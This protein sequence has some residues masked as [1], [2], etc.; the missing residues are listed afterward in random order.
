M[1]KRIAFV[2]L[3]VFLF[4]T[5][6]PNTGD[7]ALVYA[8][9]ATIEDA[10]TAVETAER[11]GAQADIDEA[12]RLI[13]QVPPSDERTELEQRVDVVQQSADV[14]LGEDFSGRAVGDVINVNGGYDVTVQ[15]D[16]ADPANLV[17]AQHYNSTPTGGEAFQH[18]AD[19]PLT[20]RV[21]VEQDVKFAG[22]TSNDRYFSMYYRTAIDNT[23]Y[24][25]FDMYAPEGGYGVRLDYYDA[26]AG[27]DRGWSE[28]PS[29]TSIRY[30]TWY[31]LRFVL[32][33]E[34]NIYEVYMTDLST[35]KEIGSVT[36]RQLWSTAD[37]S[38]GI[39]QFY[40][41]F[42]GSS[43]AQDCYLYFDNFKVTLSMASEA[44]NALVAAERSILPE[45]VE[46]AEEYI[47]AMPAGADKEAF[48]QRL[49]NVKNIIEVGPL[50]EQAVASRQQEDFDAAY[51]LV[52]Q[53]FDGYKKDEYQQMLDGIVILTP[54]LAAQEALEKAEESLLAEDARIAQEKI[55]ALED[56]AEKTAYQQRLDVVL[57]IIAAREAV[58]RCEQ[59]MQKAD[60]D[61]AQGKINRLEPGAERDALQARLDAV[62]PAS[63]EK[64]QQTRLPVDI[65]KA[66]ALVNGMVESDEKTEYLAVLH[67]IV[68][69]GG[70]ED[71]IDAV[72]LAEQT[73]LASDI[74]QAQIL[75]DG[76]E[77]GQDKS[78]LQNRLNAVRTLVA[79]IEQ[80]ELAEQSKDM[81]DAENAQLLISALPE[82]TEKAQLQK[83]VQAVID[84]IVQ[85]IDQTLEAIAQA[86]TVVSQEAID[87]AQ[88]KIDAL[89]DGLQ[90]ESLQMR[91][92]Q[93]S[94]RLD[95]KEKIAIMEE[96]KSQ[97]DLDAAV[98]V[99]AQLPDGEEKDDYLSRILAVQLINNSL[100]YEDYQDSLI[101]ESAGNY[102]MTVQADPAD[103]ENLVAKLPYT[104]EP[105]SGFG[106]SYQPSSPMTGS[107]TLE[108]KFKF[109][110]LVS[111]DRY[112]SFY[113]RR[114]CDAWGLELFQLRPAENT[115][116]LYVEFYN[117]ESQQ[118]NFAI[119]QSSATFR[120]DT[121]YQVTAVV[122]TDEG[123]LDASLTDV[124]TGTVIASG[125]GL[126]RD[127]G[128]ENIDYTQGI[129]EFYYRASGSTAASETNCNLYMDDFRVFVS[130]S[131][132]DYVITAE[133][134]QQDEDIAAAQARIDA[135][136]AGTEKTE[137]QERLDAVR[138]VIAAKEA[139]GQF[140]ELRQQSQ[141]AS[142]L[143]SIDKLPDS[144]TKD[145]L[146]QRANAVVGFGDLSVKQGD[147]E[148]DS[149]RAGT[150]TV[151]LTA[152]NNHNLAR[153][154]QLIVGLYK[155]AGGYLQM[156]ASSKSEIQNLA[157]GT[158][159]TLSASLDVTSLSGGSYQ[160]IV[161]V[162]DDANGM[163]PLNSPIIFK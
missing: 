76:L 53:L 106:S 113:A 131:A 41:R 73:R 163:A 128:L 14:V 79:A 80:V 122:N 85:V 15:T 151:S 84:E 118:N 104:V 20:G 116:G 4:T 121:W 124:S 19:P 157:Q 45:D 143:D 71:A 152:T 102:N 138:G 134:T 110:G 62:I 140:E 28:L 133:I 66:L 141:L 146:L 123:T 42:S 149:L 23:G 56:G 7:M 21:V 87:L 105:L 161:F 25:L 8:A 22:T 96:T 60:Y 119:L 48:T 155:D 91:L 12:Q 5:Y 136:V 156:Q 3:S 59:E 139:V 11:T 126:M 69:R 92:R 74:E 67:A 72:A 18:H 158:A 68:P 154:A 38:Q 57:D 109:E 94:L 49:Q 34:N 150:I 43:T 36:G 111:Y 13:V 6:F 24:R 88:E 9:A 107:I 54:E 117:P 137:L 64:A 162:W 40:V 120:A 129:S 147:V 77:E 10:R 44:R 29:S 159:Q 86:E 16:P 46:L 101:G 95:A 33:M 89:A 108:C 132:I 17:G 47:D 35:G 97:N 112:I 142:V 125:S 61:D 135:L 160:L 130:G 55:D 50:V 98:E 100:F 127:Y 99:V 37:Y 145:S 27:E 2:V 31:R 52:E 51:A 144:Y 83:R 63:I 39:S 30:N 114:R 81:A 148:L 1:M 82:S 75:V 58:A 70:L 78:G 93:V 26:A 115:G 90:K 32:D 65:D 103:P 153:T